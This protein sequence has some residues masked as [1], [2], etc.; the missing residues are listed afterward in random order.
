L[1]PSGE[2]LPLFPEPAA[3]PPEPAATPPP[4]FTKF[5]TAT[6]NYPGWRGIVYPAASPE[7]MSSAERLA[8]YASSGRFQTVEADFTFYRPQT[9]AEWRRYGSALPDA[10]PVVSKVWEEITC[11]RFPR[12]ERHGSRGGEPNPNYLS[13]EAFRREVLGPAEEGFADHLGPFVFEFGRDARPNRERKG[14]FRDRLDRF[15]AALP[16]E[17]RYAVE[18]RTREYLDAEHV[19]LLKAHGVAPVLNWW[20]HMPELSGQFDVPGSADSPFYLA[21]VLVAPG[22][23]YEDAVKF[24]TPYDR[25]KEEHPE[26]RRDAVRIAG[27]AE[28]RRKEFFLI[29][30]NRAEGSAPYTIEG[31]RKMIG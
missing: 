3:P 14:R 29:V 17:H 22:R 27:E 11:E 15:L 12:I 5:G 20:T 30:N 28:A 9:A 31:I 16:V 4:G 2:T 7:K 23:P 19:A 25:I 26:M 24:F 18:I 21:R 8:L 13:V 6:W 10:F 1:T